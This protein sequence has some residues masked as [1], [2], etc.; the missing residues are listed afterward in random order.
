MPPHRRAVST[1]RK[2]F[3]RRRLRL[4]SRSLQQLPTVIARQFCSSCPQPLDSDTP[5]LAL[6]NAL[7]LPRVNL[8]NYSFRQLRFDKIKFSPPAHTISPPQ[9]RR[10][11]H[12]RRS[13]PSSVPLGLSASN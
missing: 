3:R 13:S 7:L 8:L 12:L 11:R 10:C 9:R 2:S 6:N 5:N 1:P 4:A